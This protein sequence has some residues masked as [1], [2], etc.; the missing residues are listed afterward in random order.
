MSATVPMIPKLGWGPTKNLCR[1]CLILHTMMAIVTDG[2]LLE[3]EIVG[4]RTVYRSATW[5][6]SRPL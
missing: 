6:R 3:P 2:A 4:P 1:R 5:L